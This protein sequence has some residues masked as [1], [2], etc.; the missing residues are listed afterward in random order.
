MFPRLRFP[1]VRSSVLKRY[2]EDFAY[3]VGDSLWLQDIRRENLMYISEKLG[4]KKYLGETRDEP[5]FPVKGMIYSAMNGRRCVNLVVG[6]G[7]RKVYVPF[8]I[9]SGS[10]RSTLSEE[11]LKAL[12]FSDYIPSE[13]VV[14]IHGFE[15]TC[16]S[17][18]SNNERL[19]DINILGWQFFWLTKV[20]EDVDIEEMQVTLHR[21]KRDYLLSL[22]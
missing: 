18:A 6:L 12:G 4:S 22:K 5:S 14:N 9:D 15:D 1:A 19:K 20:Y 10:P 16:I 7:N 21:S 11:T 8:I 17:Y 2:V 3:N 13:I